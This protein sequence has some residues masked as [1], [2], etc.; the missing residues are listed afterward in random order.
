M[1]ISP[2]YSEEQT[3]GCG[4]DFTLVGEFQTEL[5]PEIWA[6]LSRQSWWNMANSSVLVTGVWLPPAPSTSSSHPGRLT[7][8]LRRSIETLRNRLSAFFLYCAWWEEGMSAQ[9]LWWM[10]QVPMVGES[11]LQ[12][13]A[14]KQ[15]SGSCLCFFLRSFWTTKVTLHLTPARFFW[16]SHHNGEMD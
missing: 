8:L 10:W 7:S 1:N 14:D 15:V 9:R 3:N 5:L 11:T 16:M 2:L 4:H 12:D 6:R 13:R